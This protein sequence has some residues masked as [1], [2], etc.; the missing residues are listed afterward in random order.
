MSIVCVS[1]LF[2]TFSA[3]FSAQPLREAAGY[4]VVPFEKGMNKIGVW[5][6]GFTD[7]FRDVKKLAQEN[8]SLHEELD[9]LK[10]E[11]AQLAVNQ[12]EYERLTALYEV[13]EEYSE[14]DKILAQVIAK[15]PGNWYSTFTIDKGRKDGIEPDMNVIAS[16]G[17]VGLVTDVGSGWATVQT[18]VDDGNNVSGMTLADSDTCMVTGNLELLD[19]GKMKFSQLIDDTG[20]V[21]VG[22]N[23]VTSHISDKYLEGILIGTISS[24]ERDSNNLT[25]TGYLVPAVDFRHLQ[26]VF[27]ITRLK[28]QKEDGADEE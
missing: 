4:V 16:G 8:A 5:F 22:E 25:C 2:T 28:E 7:N 6:S 18:I 27:V 19:S 12:K 26:E 9:A 21:A 13:D 3:D 1:L 17:L 14:Y 24:I 10:E 11:N 23:I 20:S 15:E